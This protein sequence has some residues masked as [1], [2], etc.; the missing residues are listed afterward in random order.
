MLK[1]L[2]CM[3]GGVDSLAR[4]LLQDANVPDWMSV[5]IHKD[6]EHCLTILERLPEKYHSSLQYQA[7]HDYL[8]NASFYTIVVGY[9]DTHFYW[10]DFHSNAPIERSRALAITQQFA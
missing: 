3:C 4:G 2:A 10:E 5:P 8:Q 1:I 9:D 6:K 7:L